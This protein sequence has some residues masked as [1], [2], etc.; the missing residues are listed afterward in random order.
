MI[1]LHQF[2]IS[3]FCDKIRRVLHVK[4]VPYEIREVPLVAAATPRLRKI[5][6]T[7]K[8]PCLEH[9]G[10]FLSDST[11]IAHYLE[12]RFPDPPLVPTDP[13]LRGLCHALEDWADES[14]YF[15]E[16]LLRF[17]LPHNAKRW[18]PVLAKNDPAIV[19]AA[20]PAVVPGTIKGTLRAQGLGKKSLATVLAD[21]D[22]HLDAIDGMLQGGA[23]L[24]ADR[25][26]L[27]DLS[28]F[29][30]LFCIRGADEGAAA[31]AARQR[32]GVWMDRVDAAS[33]PAQPMS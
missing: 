2:E 19:R 21:L 10:R 24:V 18:V 25:V 6:P 7:G 5:S 15:Y 9:D 31:I 1:V 32:V 3:P 33:L 26:T 8:V 16:M 29:A 30:Q 12:A 27:A 28:V 22:R 14:L 11:D 4:R 23:W 20:A 13:R 17:S